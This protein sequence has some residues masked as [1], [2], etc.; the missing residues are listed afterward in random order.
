M[1]FILLFF[2]C[3]AV[4]GLILS[5]VAHLCGLFGLQQPL[6]EATWGLHV[7]IF[8]VSLP[9]VL[10]AT[11]IGK[12]FKQKDF[13]KAALRGCRPWMRWL[14]YG[15]LGYAVFNFVRFVINTQGQVPNDDE[16]FVGFSGHWMFFYAV[17]AAIL[18]S[19]YVVRKHD[20]AR[21]CPNNHPVSPSALFCEVCGAS[22][23]EATYSR[24][25][26]SKEVS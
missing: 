8:A 2:A 23:G 20:P 17:A 6:E 13:W 11:Q 24:S 26:E 5:L 18:Y 16:A 12:E 19:A 4:I 3:L 21:R 25:E 15:L 9:A 7:G 14:V 10:V 22:M 1:G